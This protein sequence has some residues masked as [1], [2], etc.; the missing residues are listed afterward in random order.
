MKRE[1][2]ITEWMEPAER[3]DSCYGENITRLQWCEAHCAESPGMFRI[4]THPETHKI[5]L[6]RVK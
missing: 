3:L 4:I 6:E 5:A 1:N 2:R